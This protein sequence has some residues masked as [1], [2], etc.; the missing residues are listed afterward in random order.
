MLEPGTPDSRAAWFT[1]RTLA[2]VGFDMQPTY[3][4]PLERGRRDR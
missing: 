4:R 3:D 1:L 2:R